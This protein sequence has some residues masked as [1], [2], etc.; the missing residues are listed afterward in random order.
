MVRAEGR[1]KGV[2]T[3]DIVVT[4]DWYLGCIHIFYRVSCFSVTD[5]QYFRDSELALS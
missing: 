3:R 1:G 2:Y 5:E 4:S